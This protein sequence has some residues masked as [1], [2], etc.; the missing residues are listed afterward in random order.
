MKQ[1]ESQNTP[2]YVLVWFDR[3]DNKN[4]GKG[5]PSPD[6]ETL[7]AWAREENRKYPF[8]IHDVVA[9]EF[10]DDWFPAQGESEET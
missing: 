7:K 10:A 5:S 1:T 6:I 4:R 9:E 3:R 2:S 8:L